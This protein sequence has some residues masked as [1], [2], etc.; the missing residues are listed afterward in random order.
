VNAA[1]CDATNNCPYDAPHRCAD[2]SCST[3]CSAVT[4]VCSKV[5][6]GDGSCAD[7]E[8]QCT[9][10]FGC[11]VDTPVRCH[12]GQCKK[13][14]AT[15]RNPKY[16][17][18]NAQ[19]NT[20]TCPPVA[21]C[22]S[23]YEQCE[24]GSCVLSTKLCPSITYT[25]ASDEFR[26]LDG[27]CR[28]STDLCGYKMS[29]TDPRTPELDTDGNLVPLSDKPLTCPQSLPIICPNGACVGDY[30][31]CDLSTDPVSTTITGSPTSSQRDTALEFQVLCNDGS[32]RD[33]YA[34]CRKFAEKVNEAATAEAD[35]CVDYC[36]DGT[37][38]LNGQTASSVCSIVAACPVSTRRC[39]DGSCR[40][41]CA[42]ITALQCEEGNVLNVD[43]RCRPL[44]ESLHFNGC[45]SVI[46]EHY[47]C[48]S[49]E[50]A[51]G[52]AACVEKQ[53]INWDDRAKIL[54]GDSPQAHRLA[55]E[56][57]KKN[58]RN[59]AQNA[60]FATV[61]LVNQ[62]PNSIVY[63]FAAET[64]FETLDENA[65]QTSEEEVVP[66][67][68]KS[69]TANCV[70]DYNLASTSV[71]YS[72]LQSQQSYLIGPSS[73]AF[74]LT[75]YSGLQV[76]NTAD[77]SIYIE[78]VASSVYFNATNK[79]T[80][81]RI[82]EYGSGLTSAQSVVS[83][84]FSC[85]VGSGI[86]EP[87][88]VS[89]QLSSLIDRSMKPTPA[90]SDICLAKLHRYPEH[91]Y[92]AWMCLFTDD[93]RK[94]GDLRYSTRQSTTQSLRE[95]ISFISQCYDPDLSKIVD[96][97]NSSSQD[98]STL[99][100][101]QFTML[102]SEDTMTTKTPAVYAF[103]RQPTNSGQVFLPSEDT[104]FKNN[105]IWVLFVIIGG[106]CL[107]FFLFYAVIRL[108]RYSN[109]TDKIKDEIDNTE[110]EIAEM[111]QY[112]EKRRDQEI[113][114]VA[115]PL[116]I[117]LEQQKALEDITSEEKLAR[118]QQVLE[119]QQ[120]DSAERKEVIDTLEAD[121]AQALAAL[122]ALR[123]KAGNRA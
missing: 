45:S 85:S 51:S 53:S 94:S 88:D 76:D 49:R 15:F 30:A 95:A 42:D 29:E 17:L 59:V 98:P 83:P 16:K 107:I 58:G 46:S 91:G 71:L 13:Y 79:I 100:A 114:Y 44:G 74:T 25:C 82:S 7:T 110:K 80:Y 72:P 68:V 122:D 14:P 62:V 66:A 19:I 26:C 81:S 64:A 123:K 12:N 93:Q 2:G 38:I 21:S 115:N 41:S 23:S 3:D 97:S 32:W 69:C 6:C 52:P 104:F 109:K 117:S 57:A 119:A 96:V 39:Y 111:E 36:A 50:C 101:D 105:I 54:Y 116:A 10:T 102:D 63:E 8:A 121:N 99:E 120:L 77:T 28:P 73:T 1:Q 4:E 106:I 24:D 5:K 33:S 20:L 65:Q 31:S 55:E 86:I 34:D 27:T 56:E 43:G 37:C 92:S 18:T 40:K 113:G 84:V 89:V 67:D 90:P 103:I 9:T 87:F 47:Q 35:K 118:R 48:I 61:S 60:K 75:L 22:P 78:P 11:P 70:N 108:S 112:G